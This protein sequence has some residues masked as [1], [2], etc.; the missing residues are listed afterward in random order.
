MKFKTVE[1]L[2]GVRSKFTDKINLILQEAQKIENGKFLEIVIDE[3][4]VN[5]YAL[6]SSLRNFIKKDV[7][8]SKKF[9]V[10]SRKKLIYIQKIDKAKK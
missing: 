6:G 4:D 7:E 9:K 8:L 5:S 2:A 10:F 3:P 1:N